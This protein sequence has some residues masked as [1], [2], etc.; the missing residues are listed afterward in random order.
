M[1]GPLQRAPRELTCHLQMSQRCLM[2]V[3]EASGRV[4][5][6]DD[7]GGRDIQTNIGMMYLI[8]CYI[9]NAFWQVCVGGNNEN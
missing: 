6:L 7:R 9:L 8:N 4:S 5:S 2:V 3:T 1:Y